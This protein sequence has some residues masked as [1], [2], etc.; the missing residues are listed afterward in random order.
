MLRI[1]APA[2]F[3]RH[4]VAPVPSDFLARFENIQATPVLS[5]R[6]LDLIEEGLDVAIRIGVPRL[7][8]RSRARKHPPNC[9][10]VR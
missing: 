1:T 9:R 7:R 8:P 2:T 3:G 4:H 6:N 5:D 10:R